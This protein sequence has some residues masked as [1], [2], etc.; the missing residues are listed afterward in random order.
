[1]AGADRLGP[2]ASAA[3]NTKEIRVVAAAGLEGANGSRV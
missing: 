3:S 1:V 2:H